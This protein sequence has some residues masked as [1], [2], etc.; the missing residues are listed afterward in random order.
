MPSNSG[1]SILKSLEFDRGILHS[2][3]GVCPGYSAS[4]PSTS[5]Y[6]LWVFGVGSGW[7]FKTSPLLL[8]RLLQ[9]SLQILIS[10]SHLFIQWSNSLIALHESFQ[11]FFQI[12]ACTHCVK[13]KV[14]KTSAKQLHNYAHGSVKV[15]DPF[16]VFFAFFG[17]V[18]EA[19]TSQTLSSDTR[20]MKIQAWKQKEKAQR[21]THR[22]AHGLT[23][24]RAAGS[25][26][27]ASCGRSENGREMEMHLDK[28]NRDLNTE[29]TTKSRLRALKL[30]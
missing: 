7:A 3:R 12:H 5:E 8:H 29:I 18:D 27:G 15:R 26:T 4:S 28:L 17:G 11:P 24:G 1:S 10:I 23:H 25:E 21:W 30:T 13:R 9:L 16:F 14:G 22:Q 20:G 19:R 2:L 6:W